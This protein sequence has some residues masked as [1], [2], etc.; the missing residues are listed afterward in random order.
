M[1]TH[2]RIFDAL[3][4]L[5]PARFRR[6]FGREMSQIFADC[7]ENRLS[8]WLATFKDL[9]ISLLRE[10]NREWTAPDSQ[11][12]FT[13]I[14]DFIL[15]S[16]VVG[17]NLMGWGWLAAAVTLHVDATMGPSLSPQLTASYWYTIALTLLFA[18][19][20]ISM[21]ALIGILSALV[22][23]RMGRP[24]DTHIKV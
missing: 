2:E 13:G 23:G 12:D 10:W 6:H 5:Y 17:F 18:V 19:T 1:N 11:I 7:F 3:L 21:A 16:I 4:Q 15:V 14:V 22:V 9:A 8:F 24:Q 20:F